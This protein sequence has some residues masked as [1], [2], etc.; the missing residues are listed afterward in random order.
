MYIRQFRLN[1]T[2]LFEFFCSHRHA[3][4]SAALQ[5]AVEMHIFLMLWYFDR[6]L[7]LL[8]IFM[9]KGVN[10]NPLK[11]YLCEGIPS[12]NFSIIHCVCF[13]VFFRWI[14]QA[15][16][17]W[18]AKDAISIVWFKKIVYISNI[19][20]FADCSQKISSFRCVIDFHLMWVYCISLEIGQC[21]SWSSNYTL[22]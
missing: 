6:L 1:Q 11:E 7:F 5:N 9:G 14:R 21:G 13:F 22:L 4:F 18:N 12:S 15:N 2:Y 10:L 16:G 8:L 17:N 20:F 19:F 3:I